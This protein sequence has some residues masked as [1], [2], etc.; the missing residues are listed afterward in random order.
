MHAQ[1]LTGGKKGAASAREGFESS[2]RIADNGVGFSRPSLSPMVDGNKLSIAALAKE[3]G[4]IYQNGRIG[5][6][7]DFQNA[8]DC[9]LH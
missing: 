4:L 1:E 3:C 6:K 7:A 8:A 9:G 2:K 5:T